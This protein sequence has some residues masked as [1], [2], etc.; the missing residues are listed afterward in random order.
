MFLI[1]VL[2][3]VENPA[4]PLTLKPSRNAGLVVAARAARVPC[5]CWGG[6]LGG[7]GVGDGDGGAGAGGGDG[8][9]LGIGAGAVGGGGGGGCARGVYSDR[10]TRRGCMSCSGVSLP[11]ALIMA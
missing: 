8:G 4:G 3:R 7:A 10:E 1:L 11:I 9:T 6:G 5:E 2:L